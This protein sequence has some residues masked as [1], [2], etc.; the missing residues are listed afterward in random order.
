MMLPKGKV[1]T[2][3]GPVDPSKLGRVLMYEHLHCDI[4]DW[5]KMELATEEKPMTAQRREFMLKEA[6]PL[7]HKCADDGCHAFVEAS[8]SPWRAWPTFYAEASKAANVDIILCTGFYREVEVGKYWVKTEEDAIWPFVR[9]ASIDELADFCTR[10]IQEG[11][12]GTGVHAGAIKLASSQPKMTE[13]EEKT[14]V[15]GARAQRQT[16]VHITTHC[17]NFGVETNQLQLFLDEG[18]D[19]NRVAVG[20]TAW[21]LMD[22][23]ERQMCALNGWNAARASFRRPSTSMETRIGDR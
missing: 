4:Y 6:I 17:T 22:A 21:H 20:H 16:G 2:V 3:R 12:H 18:V 19:L 1:L 13:A 15:A 5:E 23:K 9:K 7:L 11:I 8:P 14:F 10:E